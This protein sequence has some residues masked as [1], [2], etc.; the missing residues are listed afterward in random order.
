MPLVQAP[1]HH[2]EDMDS[3][4]RGMELKV[5]ASKFSGCNGEG[6]IGDGGVPTWVILTMEA[7]IIDTEPHFMWPINFF[8]TLNNFTININKSLFRTPIVTFQ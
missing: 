1:V 4:C 6:A 2:D 5:R 3:D 8:K 7:E